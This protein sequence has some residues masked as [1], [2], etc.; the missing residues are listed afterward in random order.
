MFLNWYHKK[1]K[2]WQFWLPQSGFLGGCIAGSIIFLACSL[3][4]IFIVLL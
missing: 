1:A 3:I 2:W 4:I